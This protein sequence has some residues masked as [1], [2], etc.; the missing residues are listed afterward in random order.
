MKE[1]GVD[2]YGRGAGEQPGGLKWGEINQDVLY[3][4]IYFK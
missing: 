3:E 1:K 4:E 2:L